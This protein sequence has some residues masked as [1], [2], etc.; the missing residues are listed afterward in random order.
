[1]AV[2]V[3][4][5]VGYEIAELKLARLSVVGQK[6]GG[7]VLVAAGIVQLGLTI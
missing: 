1:L 6:L 5:G 7:I 3:A 2:T 4:I